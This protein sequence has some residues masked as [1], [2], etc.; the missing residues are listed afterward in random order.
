MTSNAFSRQFHYIMPQ[1]T[2]TLTGQLR[3]LEE[4]GIVIRKVFPEV[5][6]KVEYSLSEI[7]TTLNPVLSQL[8]YWGKTYHAYPFAVITYNFS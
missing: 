8:C 5:P 4:Q 1:T 2:K 7:G 3:E 6:P